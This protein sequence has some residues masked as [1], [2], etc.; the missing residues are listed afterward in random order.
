M[1]VDTH[2]PSGA[3]ASSSLVRHAVRD[4]RNVSQTSVERSGCSSNTCRPR[5]LP[6]AS[7]CRSGCLAETKKR[8]GR[9]SGRDGADDE[10]MW[11]GPVCGERRDSGI[12]GRWTVQQRRFGTGFP[13]TLRRRRT[14]VCWMRCS[15]LRVSSAAN[16]VGSLV[17]RPAPPPP[18]KGLESFQV[19]VHFARLRQLAA[20]AGNEETLSTGVEADRGRSRS[21]RQHGFTT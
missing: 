21:R 19:S 8:G 7:W 6:N 4:N 1:A 18:G 5:V 10:R 12:D 13:V 14:L 16:D 11:P 3:V 15:L 17:F 9:R 2:I 20:W